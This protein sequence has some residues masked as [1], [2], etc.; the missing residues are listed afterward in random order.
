MKEP[1]IAQVLEAYDVSL[2]RHFETFEAELSKS[3]WHDKYVLKLRVTS[4]N[5][6]PDSALNAAAFTFGLEGKETWV[7]PNTWQYE[8]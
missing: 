2:L 7:S 5:K 3:K 4:G 8:K 6:L 1:L